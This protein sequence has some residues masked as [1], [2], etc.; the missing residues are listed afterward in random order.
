[1]TVLLGKKIIKGRGERLQGGGGRG[2]AGCFTCMNF[3]RPFEM[4]SEFKRLRVS[5]DSGIRDCV[6][7]PDLEGKLL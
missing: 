4:R 2:A 7:K 1:M 6:R 3:M 5:L